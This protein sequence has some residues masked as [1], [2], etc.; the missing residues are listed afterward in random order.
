[1]TREIDM[2]AEDWL[3]QQAALEQIDTPS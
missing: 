2:L 3:F 1:L